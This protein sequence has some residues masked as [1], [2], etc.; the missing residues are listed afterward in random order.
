MP[1]IPLR[2]LFPLAALAVFVSCGK[3]DFDDKI[4]PYFFDRDCEVSSPDALDGFSEGCYIPLFLDDFSDNSNEWNLKNQ[5]E[6]VHEITGGHLTLSTHENQTNIWG[7]SKE[8]PGFSQFGD[9]EFSVLFRIVSVS[10]GSEAET[11]LIL[12]GSD[13][14]LDNYQAFSFNADKEFEA[15]QVSNSTYVSHRTGTLSGG[16]FV[17]NSYIRFTARNYQDT[18]YFFL[19]DILFHQM[20]KQPLFGD[21]IFLGAGSGNEVWMDEV[22]VWGL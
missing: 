9:W 8:V 16:S 21:R 6:Y 14:D 17:S 12:W 13:E 3:D 19:D 7:M 18:A 1:H 10:N 15:Y 11:N 5:F 2:L 20:P 22:G 4:T